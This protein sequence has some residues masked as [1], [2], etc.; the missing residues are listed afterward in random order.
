M[1]SVSFAT[2]A[3]DVR[4]EIYSRVRDPQARRRGPPRALLRRS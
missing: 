3:N 2:S 1:S 4:D